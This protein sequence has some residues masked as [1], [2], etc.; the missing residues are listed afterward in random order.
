MLD[1][2]KQVQKEY[3]AKRKGKSITGASIRPYREHNKGLL[4]IYGISNPKGEDHPYGGKDD[5]YNHT[6]YPYYGF[7]L[8]FPESDQ[9]VSN[10]S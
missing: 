8:S 7:Q 1:L 10:L 4:L 5:K 6:D 3:K 9:F 2:P